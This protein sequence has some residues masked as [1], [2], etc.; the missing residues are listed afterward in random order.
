LAVEALLAGTMTEVLAVLQ[1][2]L[3]SPEHAAFVQ[4]RSQ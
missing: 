1:T 4:Q 2:G 3:A